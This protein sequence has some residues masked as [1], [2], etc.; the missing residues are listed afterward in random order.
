M[1]DADLSTRSSG[2]A[3]DNKIADSAPPHQ[4]KVTLGYTPVLLAKPVTP[5]FL[6]G[7]C[8]AVLDV[9]YNFTVTPRRHHDR[10]RILQSINPRTGHDSTA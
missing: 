3:S 2:K 8:Y 9:L 5:D 6:F 7:H 4:N 10:F 1:D